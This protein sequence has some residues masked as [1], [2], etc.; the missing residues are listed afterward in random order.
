M[1]VTLAVRV[2]FAPVLDGLADEL[3]AT[4]VAPRF[5][6]WREDWALSTGE[7]GV[8][9]VDRRDGVRPRPGVGDCARRRARGGDCLGTAAGDDDTA[10][11]KR[12]RAGTRP[13]RGRDGADCGGVRHGLTAHRRVDRRRHDR[14]RGSDVD[15]LGHRADVLGEYVALPL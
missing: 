7:I 13:R 1:A 12:H 5:T 15:H 6:V 8:A 4:A 2:T 10:I 14:G 11:L 3:S 9:A